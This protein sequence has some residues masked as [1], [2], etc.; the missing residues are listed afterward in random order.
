MATNM[1]LADLC[2]SSTPSILKTHVQRANEAADQGILEASRPLA[3]TFLHVAR[4]L[5]D[6]QLA[7]FFLLSGMAKC[8]DYAFNQVQM[9][10]LECERFETKIAIRAAIS[11]VVL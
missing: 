6:H 5:S 11:R 3:E 8:S 7:Q 4:G 10:R 1:A 2:V 9:I